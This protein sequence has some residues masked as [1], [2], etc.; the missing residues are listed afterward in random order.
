M[1]FAGEEIE[2]GSQSQNVK[3]RVY[4]SISRLFRWIEE[5]DYRAYDTFD[6]LSS[7]FLRPLT[8]ETRTL[9][10]VLLQG[11]RRFPLNLRPILGIK[12]SRSTKGM[13]FLVRGFL[14]L[15]QSTGDPRWLER[16]EA[17]LQ[18]LMDNQSKGYS[19]V[20]WGNHFDYQSRGFYLPKGVPTIV[21]TSLIGHA[22]LDAYEYLK[23]KEYLDVAVSACGHILQDIERYPEADGVCIS[24]VPNLDCRV[25][26]ANTL[27]GSLLARAYSHTQDPACR[28]LAE[29]AL[30]Y[31][32]NHQRINGSW[33]Y[34][35]KENLH[36]VDNF[37]SGYV[38][39]CFKHYML[40]TGDTQFKP[41]MD[42]GYEYWK[43]TFF[44]PD[45]TPRYYDYKTL[46]IDIQCCSQA[47]DTLMFFREHDLDSTVLASRVAL[48][49]IEHMQDR[50]GYFY[51]RRYSNRLV[52]K[53]PTL[54]WGQA[55]MLC[56]LAALHQSL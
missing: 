2:H 24:Y 23:R 27:G 52:N 1:E 49:T 5:N 12:K 43:R 10:T 21:W 15:H 11:V 6:G 39:D 26:N 56:S 30:R 32:A 38:L 14:R 48:W 53:T 17:A 35:E 28:E 19:G 55:T 31:T 33:Y 29:K 20:C 34:G 46:P 16:A 47:I 7:P 40:A 50:S 3:R 44:L 13:G 51:Y 45:G 8:F 25:H 37:H 22:F 41:V 36:W 4:E 42:K 18:W 9:R 54:H